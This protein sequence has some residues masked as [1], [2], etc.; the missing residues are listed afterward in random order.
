MSKKQNSCQ[1]GETPSSNLRVQL[2]NTRTLSD[3]LLWSKRGLNYGVLCLIERQWSRYSPD[4]R[5]GHLSHNS[6]T[7]DAF[8]EF[9]CETTLIPVSV[10]WI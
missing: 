3:L 7:F 2:S 10:Y 9:D 8:N 6:T 1:A 5:F 4:W